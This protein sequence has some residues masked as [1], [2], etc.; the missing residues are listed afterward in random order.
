MLKNIRYNLHIINC[1]LK[2]HVG[3]KDIEDNTD[4]VH[5]FFKEIIPRLGLISEIIFLNASSV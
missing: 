5:S 2:H 4:L 3:N 1:S